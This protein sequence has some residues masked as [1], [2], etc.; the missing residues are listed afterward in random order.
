MNSMFVVSA[1]V[2]ADM[3]RDVAA[4]MVAYVSAFYWATWLDLIS[5]F[6]TEFTLKFHHRNAI[7]FITG[8]HMVISLQFAK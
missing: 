5:Y 6:V 2:A 8:V 3:S 7:N 1:S 4:N